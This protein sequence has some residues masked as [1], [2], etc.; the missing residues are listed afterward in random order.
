MYGLLKNTALTLLSVPPEPEAP[1]GSQGSLLVFRA[2]PRYLRYR[3]LLWALSRIGHLLLALIVC[4]AMFTPALL[5]ARQ[6]SP[7][8]A[9]PEATSEAT[10]S[11]STEAERAPGKAR[12]KPRKDLFAEVAPAA[13]RAVVVVL[14]C[15][16]LAWFLVQSMI[17][18]TLLRLDYDMHWYKVTDR[19]LRIREGVWFVREMTMS[20]AN[21]QNISMSQGPLQKYFGVSDLVVESAGGG[22]GREGQP[23]QMNLHRGVFR[24]VD[25]AEALREMMLERLRQL[26]DGGLG[27]H[28]DHRRPPRPGAAVAAGAPPGAASGEGQEEGAAAAVAGLLGE[29]RAFRRAAERLKG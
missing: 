7:A 25:N 12:R 20:F 16:A 26:K 17:S 29:A 24:G 10:Q 27:E 3:L 9:R 8:Q 15:V 28:E 19:S 4:A 11:P 6:F 13:I 14:A 5:I 18:Y 22:G 23:G 21:I 1:A 2:S